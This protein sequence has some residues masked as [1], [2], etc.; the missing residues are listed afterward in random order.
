VGMTEEEEKLIEEAGAKKVS[1]GA[2]SLHADHC[3]VL[4][5]WI[6]DVKTIPTERV[7]LPP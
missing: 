1:L 6:L 5:N 7:M 4:I 2:T 3:V